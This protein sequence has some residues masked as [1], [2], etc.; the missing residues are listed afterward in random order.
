MSESPFSDAL[1]GLSVTRGDR[2]AQQHS[3]S[4]GSWL[5]YRASNSRDRPGALLA[6]A[7]D[8][9]LATVPCSEITQPEAGLYNWNQ[10]LAE[11]GL[12]QLP[13]AWRGRCLT[14]TN[15]ESPGYA[16]RSLPAARATRS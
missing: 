15:R 8:G 14:G 10:V 5:R 12:P 16:R 6:K 3:Y 11:Y 7:P 13:I 9:S 4:S 2:L 1:A